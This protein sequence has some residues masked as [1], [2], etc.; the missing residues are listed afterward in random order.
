MQAAAIVAALPAGVVKVGLFVN[1]PVQR[2]LE[3]RDALRLDLIQLHGDEPPEYLAALES[4]PVMRAFRLQSPSLAGIVQY[5]AECRR[6]GCMPR[7]VLIDA[8]RADQYGGT[9]RVADWDTARQ[10]PTDKEYPP[11]VLAG[12][13]TLQNVRAAIAA[14]RPYAVDCSSGVEIAPGTKDAAKVARFVAEAR[15]ALAALTSDAPS[16]GL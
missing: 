7:L 9:G 12:G 15:A 16:L 13:L 11:L 2:V 6:L 5:L 10:Y 8:Y 14:V 1:A 4:V 3:M